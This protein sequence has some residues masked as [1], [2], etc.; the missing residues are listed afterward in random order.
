MTLENKHTAFNEFFSIEHQFN[1]NIT[2]LEANELNHENFVNSIP[3]PFKIASEV[4]RIE[5]SAI[6]PLASL[7]HDAAQL[8]TF[9]NNQSQ[10]ID[11]LVSYILNQEDNINERFSGIQVGGAGIVFESSAPYTD[12]KSLSL[13]LFFTQENCAVFCYGEI[14]SEE[15]IDNKY[16]YKVLFS[17]IQDEDRE[18]L[19]RASLHLQSKQLKKLAQQRSQ[20]SL[21]S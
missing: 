21:S 16:R 20:N 3:L 9:L 6:N 2:P 11:L 7:K 18:T 17:Q 10:K 8:V 19:V 5:Q 4:N 15:Q 12:S 13:K 1:I 14:I